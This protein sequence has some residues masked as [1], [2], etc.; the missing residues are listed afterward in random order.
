MSLGCRPLFAIA[1]VKFRRSNL[2]RRDA[3]AV[4][5]ED[6]NE[7]SPRG[8]LVAVEEAPIDRQV[9]KDVRRDAQQVGVL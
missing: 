2:I 1:R 5:V 7:R 6:A 3:H 4:H 9:R 8:S